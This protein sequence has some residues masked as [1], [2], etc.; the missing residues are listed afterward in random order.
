MYSTLGM[1]GFLSHIQKMNHKIFDVSN[2]S[3]FIDKNPRCQLC[4][5]KKKC[6]CSMF[7]HLITQFRNLEPRFD[8][9]D[10]MI[11][12]Y[13]FVSILKKNLNSGIEMILHSGA[14][15][16]IIEFNPS[17]TQNIKM[18]ITKELKQL[19]PENYGKNKNIKVGKT[20][21]GFYVCHFFWN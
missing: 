4:F 12:R 7:V 14:K 15:G 3:Q 11:L 19:L 13:I 18:K 9:D 10:I 20:K 2:F 6:M 1:K 16:Y 5:A 8:Q 17:I 21:R